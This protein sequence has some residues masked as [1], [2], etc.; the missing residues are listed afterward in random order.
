MSAAIMRA[1]GGGGQF[2]AGVLGNGISHPLAVK[3]LSSRRNLPATRVMVN[4]VNFRP[5]PVAASRTPGR[6]RGEV[7]KNPCGATWVLAGNGTRLHQRCSAASFPGRRHSM[8]FVRRFMAAGALALAVF[9][10][11]PSPAL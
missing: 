4:E 5:V 2:R 1:G 8:A 3:G 10:V 9:A 11:A 7:V 6:K